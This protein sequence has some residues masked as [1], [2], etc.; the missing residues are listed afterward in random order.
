MNKS[1]AFN[2]YMIYN[3][4]IEIKGVFDMAKKRTN[5]TLSRNEKELIGVEGLVY[6]YRKAIDP[7]G[8]MLDIFP[9][10]VILKRLLGALA[11]AVADDY[12][13]MYE[14]A[15]MEWKDGK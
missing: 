11:H 2:V 5:M 3:V 10:S 4:Y 15:R 13:D 8:N 1:V 6:E 12:I 9:D 14:L 7:N